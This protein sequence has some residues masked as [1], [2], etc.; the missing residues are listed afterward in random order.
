[1]R[2]V[3]ELPPIPS[4]VD[5]HGPKEQIVLWVHRCKWDFQIIELSGSSI[6]PQFCRFPSTCKDSYNNHQ[7]KLASVKGAD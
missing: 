1:M 2:I 4:E 6:G 7:K 3:I 5:P